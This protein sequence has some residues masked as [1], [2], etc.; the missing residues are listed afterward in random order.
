MIETFEINGIIQ[1]KLSNNE[2]IIAYGLFETENYLCVSNPLLIEEHYMNGTISLNFSRYD[3]FSE[4]HE[5]TVIDKRQ[6]VFY[7]FASVNI[8]DYYLKFKEYLEKIGDAK[9]EISLKNSTESLDSYISQHF[10]RS[11]KKNVN[12]ITPFSNTAH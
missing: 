8:I 7:N 2:D 12:I 5:K 9:Q 11:K 4:N 1:I 6:I 10:N 3:S